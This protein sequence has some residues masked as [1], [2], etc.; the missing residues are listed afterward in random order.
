MSIGEMAKT[1]LVIN[2]I[3]AVLLTLYLYLTL[4]AFLGA[5]PGVFPEWSQQMA[6]PAK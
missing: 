1:G 3:G 5:D 2:I 4:P 6:S